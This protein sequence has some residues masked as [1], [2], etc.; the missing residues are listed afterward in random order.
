LL[1]RSILMPRPQPRACARIL[2]AHVRCKPSDAATFSGG[3]P[4]AIPS[5]PGSA[6]LPAL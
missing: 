1:E 4:S 5:P 2:Y 3:S 6:S